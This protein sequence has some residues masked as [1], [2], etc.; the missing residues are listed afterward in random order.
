MNATQLL[1]L[2]LYLLCAGA[3]LIFGYIWKEVRNR[4]KRNTQTSF[5]FK[6]EQGRET[7]EQKEQHRLASVRH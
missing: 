5:K 2:A 6:E 3:L 1:I 4:H 7:E